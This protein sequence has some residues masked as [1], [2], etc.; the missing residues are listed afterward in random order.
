VTKAGGTQW[1]PSGDGVEVAVH[2]LG[3]TGSPLLLAHATGFCG[4]SLEPLAQGLGRHF[5]CWAFDARGQGDTRAPADLEYRWGSLADDVLAVAD[6]LGLQDLYGVGHSGGGAA[7]LMAEAR[8]SGLFR[9]LYCF[10]PILWP[11]PARGEE[12]ARRLAEGARRRRA[13]FASRDDAYANYAAKPPF[14]AFD[15]RALRAYLDHCLADAAD[16][17]VALKCS[18]DVEARL[19]LA[20]PREGC[21]ALEDVACPVVVA[22]AGRHSALGDVAE[23]Q[24]ATLPRGRLEEWPDLTHFGP[25]E[26]P[27]AVAAAVERTFA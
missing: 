12:R 27:E 24:V 19:Y 15:E 6:G 18:P 9:A 22:R 21:S 20:A 3:G 2:D 7:L 8:R 16:G 26:D 1:F 4:R 23:R 5:R 11:E 14:S 10:E 17:T 25:L 13:A